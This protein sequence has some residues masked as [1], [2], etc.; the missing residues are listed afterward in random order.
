MHGVA[1]VDLLHASQW[2][3][4]EH[5]AYMTTPLLAPDAWLSQTSRHTLE[6][7]LRGQIG[8]SVCVGSDSSE[9][10][11]M[12]L[13]IGFTEETEESSSPLL[14]NIDLLALLV[15]LHA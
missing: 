12:K 8:G 1:E 6:A 2:L 14:V 7:S 10:N 9:R 13:G 4:T 5:A 11:R 3:R 15:I